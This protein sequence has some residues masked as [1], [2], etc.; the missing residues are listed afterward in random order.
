MSF[1]I[2]SA[3]DA[4]QPSHSAK[5]QQPAAGG[6]PF[7]AQLQDAHKD[8]SRFVA[9]PEESFGAELNAK[10]RRAEAVES[11]HEAQ[12]GDEDANVYQTVHELTKKLKALAELERR[13]AGM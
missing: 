6:M 1:A 7:S 4:H 12:S 5:H 2:Q 9:P 8:I 10:K 11:V 13:S 3:A